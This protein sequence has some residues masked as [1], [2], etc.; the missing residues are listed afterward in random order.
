[1]TAAEPKHDVALSFLS[2]DLK[3]AQKFNRFL[4]KS[5]NVF[6]YP[7]QQDTLAGPD[8]M[9]GMRVAFRRDSRVNVILYGKRW[10][11][12]PWTNFEQQAIQ[13]RCMN[14]DGWKRL[15]V[16][17]LEEDGSG[18]A[19]VPSSF[20]VYNLAA[21]GVEQAIGAIVARVLDA[22]GTVVPMTPIRQAEL[23]NEEENYQAA[24]R[25][26]MSFGGDRM[27]VAKDALFAEIRRHSD[28][29]L[30]REL[31]SDFRIGVA[32]NSL[33]LG[34]N[35]VTMLLALSPFFGAPERVVLMVRTAEGYDI[36]P[37]ERPGMLYEQPKPLGRTKYK[38]DIDQEGEVIWT[39]GNTSYS[40]AEMAATVMGQFMDLVRQHFNRSA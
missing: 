23:H 31:I 17:S 1:M 7:H 19:W 16:I 36:L 13:D 35:R 5:L 27:Q 29:I 11:N 9:E 22:G 24:R 40:S 14:A 28:E 34:T 33:G 6:F 8:A 3:I 39:L 10:G 12:T 2:S 38:P 30:R 25:E 20:I 21:F 26:F 37:G 4:R 15:V 18:P 32:P